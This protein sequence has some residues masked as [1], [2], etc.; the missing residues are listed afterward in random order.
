MRFRP[1]ANCCHLE[2]LQGCP[3]ILGLT[4][5]I[6][7]ALSRGTDRSHYLEEI[8]IHLI[9]RQRDKELSNCSRDFDSVVFLLLYV[10]LTHP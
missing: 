1:R 2:E 6:N 3:R 7:I 4:L 9:I 10:L 5:L 8:P